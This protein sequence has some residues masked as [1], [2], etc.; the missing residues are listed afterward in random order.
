MSVSRNIIRVFVPA[1]FACLFCFSAC[2]EKTIEVAEDNAEP[3]YLFTSE[4]TLSD[5]RDELEIA[6][7]PDVPGWFPDDDIYDIPDGTFDR[8]RSGHPWLAVITVGYLDIRN[9]P[10]YGTYAKVE[11]DEIEETAGNPESDGTPQRETTADEEKK[12]TYSRPGFVSNVTAGMKRAE[13]F[14]IIRKMPGESSGLHWYEIVTFDGKTG[15]VYLP[16][17]ESYQTRTFAHEK[18][19]PPR[20]VVTS[21]ESAFYDASNTEI[22]PARYGD[23]FTCKNLENRAGIVYYSIIIPDYGDAYI[24]V[25]DCAVIAEDIYYSIYLSGS[26]VF[27]YPGQL[28]ILKELLDYFERVDWFLSEYPSGT[29][30]PLVLYRANYVALAYGAPE[31]A[32]E[33]REKLIKEYPENAKNLLGPGS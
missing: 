25:T 27:D 21:S 26:R 9:A 2:K 18:I 6:E 33:Y 24:P 15:F 1:V 12:P 29:N 11:P 4:E 20:I 22:A 8:N 30:A 16:R 23:I 31:K 14:W 28:D 19:V 3:E 17:T 10:G 7:I 5:Y 13:P 32:R